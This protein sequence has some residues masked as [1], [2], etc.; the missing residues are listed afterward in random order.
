MR[1]LHDAILG[2][3]EPLGISRELPVANSAEVAAAYSGTRTKSTPPA[4]MAR[5]PARPSP[6]SA[7]QKRPSGPGQAGRA[8]PQAHEAITY[9][10]PPAPGS[11]TG[12]IAGLGIAALAAAVGVIFFVV[13]QQGEENRQAAERA[14]RITAERVAQESRDAAGKAEEAAKAQQNEKVFLSVVSEPMG[15]LAEVTWKDGAKAAATPFDL[16]VPK[17]AKVH[18]AFSKRDYFSYA[19]DVIA[20]TPQVVKATLQG[21]ARAAQTRR[22]GR[23]RDD[24]PGKGARQAAAPDSKSPDDT[25]PVEF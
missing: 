12:L 23:S 3:M 4:T 1:H 9:Q 2:V 13:R 8:T 6:R 17:N 7:L 20:D 5:T 14:A 11:R 18:V 22:L 21:G 16:S 15:A 10:L 25:F 19:T 24:E